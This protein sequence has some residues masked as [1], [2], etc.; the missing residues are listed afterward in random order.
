MPLL[1]IL[2]LRAKQYLCMYPATCISLVWQKINYLSPFSRDVLSR[3]PVER[4]VAIH[5]TSPRSAYLADFRQVYRD[6]NLE[7]Q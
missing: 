2:Y 1:T 5:S 7:S 3:L 6:E 4:R